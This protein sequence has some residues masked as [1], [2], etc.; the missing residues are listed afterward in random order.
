MVAQAFTNGTAY[1]T[2]A[3]LTTNA[4]LI[5][6]IVGIETAPEFSRTAIDTTHSATTDGWKTFIAGDIKDAGMIAI[7]CHWSTQLD[8]V[9]LFAAG[10]D[11]ITITF[12][13][14]A[15]SCGGSLA[16]TAANW[17]CS[18]VFEKISPKWE[19]DGQTVVTLT[20]KISGKPTITAAV[21]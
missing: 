2:T 5:G 3:V 12:P 16:A 6:P 19:F 10:C 1:G 21:A 18:V 13:K 9:T 8:Y 7:T 15:T 14:R 4:T 17:A 20:F 11:T